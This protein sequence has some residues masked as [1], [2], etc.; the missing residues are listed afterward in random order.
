MGKRNLSTREA[1]EALYSAA[2]D[3]LP[4][5]QS[6]LS[7]DE[8]LAQIPA[9]RARAEREYR[10]GR[11]AVAAHYDARRNRVVM[12]LSNG[13][14]FGFPVQ[15]IPSLAE[16]TPDELAAVEV[17]PRGTGLHWEALDMDLSVAGLLVGAIPRAE[18]RR[19]L[20]RLAGQTTSPAKS[21]AA[22]ENG[23]RGGRP[24]VK[25]KPHQA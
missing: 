24:R 14:V 4:E 9:A 11:L 13:C 6:E 18:R 25:V 10:A 3:A 5:V 17:S 8:V 22:R 12:E 23:K 7:D 2:P 21:A 20:A 19:E 16:A 15:M 1:P